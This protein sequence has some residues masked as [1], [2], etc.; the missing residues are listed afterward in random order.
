[1]EL[2]VDK[3]TRHNPPSIRVTNKVDKKTG[4]QVTSIRLNGEVEVGT[5]DGWLC[6]WL[7]G[8]EVCIGPLTPEQAEKLAEDLGYEAVSGNE[9]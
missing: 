8:R 6:F 4:C 5:R 2:K 1:M 3:H 9:S 7:A